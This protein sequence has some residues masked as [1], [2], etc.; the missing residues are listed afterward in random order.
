MKKVILILMVLALLP[1]VSGLEECQEIETANIGCL[2]VTPVITCNNYDSYTPAYAKDADGTVMTQIGSTG[3]YYFTF[4]ESTVGAWTI[5]LCSNHTSQITIGI[6]DQANMNT[7]NSTL[8][9]EVDDLEEN[10]LSINTSIMDNIDD[11]QTMLVSINSTLFNEVDNLEE[12]LLLINTS[13]M[14]NVDDTQTMLIS[15]NSTL[16]NEVDTLEENWSAYASNSTFIAE[17]VFGYNLTSAGYTD[18]RDSGLF[19]DI[20]KAMDLAIYWIERLLS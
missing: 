9:N 5:L 7:I 15:V 10:L 1:L 2:V 19:G 11:T 12:D 16:Y 14:T 13:I 8:F 3:V 17:S 6:T 4:N 20:V 18:N